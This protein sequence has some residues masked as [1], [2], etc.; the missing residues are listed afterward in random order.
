M[1][2]CLYA[3][4]VIRKMRRVVTSRFD[5][6]TVH[7]ELFRACPYVDTVTALSKPALDAYTHA[8]IRMFEPKKLPHFS[9]DTFDFISIPLNLGQLTFAE[10]QLEYFAVERDQAE[11]F[12][13]VINTSMT[14]R[15]RSWPLDNWQRLA[16]SL[17][18]KGLNVAVVGKDVESKVDGMVKRS[19]PL[20]GGVRNLVNRLSLDQTYYTI[21]K[22]RLFVTPQGG[23][24][25]LAGATDTKIIV[26]GMAIEWSRRAIYRH[27]NP[28][29]K[30]TYVSG[31]CEVYCGRVN[32]CE[33]PEN[34]FK[35]IPGYEEVERAVLASAELAP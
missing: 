32:E 3:L 28:F 34:N 6:F 15:T 23:L 9:M 18:A 7:P 29:Y 35:C 33:V 14:W 25:V 16:D 10:K 11:A 8:C 27:A 21:R 20:A 24:S 31:T 17:T 30:V 12:D 4:A 22:A 5:L 2:D 1:G 26:L 19:P 13:V